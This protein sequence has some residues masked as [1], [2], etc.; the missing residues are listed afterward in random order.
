MEHVCGVKGY[1]MLNNKIYSFVNDSSSS[2]TLS[3]GGAARTIGRSSKMSG[4]RV[5]NRLKKYGIVKTD[6]PDTLRFSES[7]MNSFGEKIKRVNSNYYCY[8]TGTEYHVK[9]ANRV[10]LNLSTK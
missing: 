4:T 6:S 7:E 1:R 5:F 9:R 3:R 8:Y 10:I 2:A